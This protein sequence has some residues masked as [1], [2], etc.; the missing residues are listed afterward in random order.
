MFEDASGTSVL[1]RVRSH[2][3]DP[4][5]LEAGYERIEA[6]TALD[7]LIRQ[8]QAEQTVQVVALHRERSQMMGL[9][10]PDPGLTVAG[11]VGMARNIGPAVAGHQ[12]AVGLGLARLPQV[13]ELFKIGVIPESVARAV[14]RETD[15]LD[16]E[17]LV[18]ADAEIAPL[19][20]GCT[21]IRADRAAARVV[22]G[23]DADAAH[24][25]AVKNRAGARVEMRSDP[26]GV[27][28]LWVRGPAEKITAAYQALDAWAV[29]LRSTGD[30]RT[31]GQVMVDTLVERVTGLAS[32][33]HIDVEIH[34]V[35]DAPTLIGDGDTPAE[36]IG[37][38]PITPSVA[39]DL[40]ATA[41]NASVRRLLTD[42]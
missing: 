4:R 29:G 9:G 25:R 14:V 21:T 31:R 27:A 18:V 3:F 6:I 40:I 33:D 36:L 42:P 7:R 16:V 2:D 30:P 34:L 17:D 1:A 37:H 13:F 23:L 12:L 39:D 5:P 28:E 15:A 22:I 32:A 38:G 35:M 19:L 41:R 20:P 8:A 26:D 24:E 10:D 11:E